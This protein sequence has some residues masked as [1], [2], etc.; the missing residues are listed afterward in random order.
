M[1]DS[2]ALCALK[3]LR[4]RGIRV[5]QDI[6]V[7]GFDDILLGLG[8][9]LTTYNFNISAV[10]R[11]MLD[12]VFGGPMTRRGKGPIEI[13]GVIIER[14]STGKAGHSNY[15]NRTTIRSAESSPILTK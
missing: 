7:I 4:S 1:D 11:A 5:P 2:T 6:A 10:V 15:G 8:A 9:G 13:P 12:H 3:Y 14:A